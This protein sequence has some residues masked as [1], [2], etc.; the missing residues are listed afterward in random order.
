MNMQ[1]FVFGKGK[2]KGCSLIV[3][4]SC[5]F[6]FIITLFIKLVTNDVYH[7]HFLTSGN[8]VM[9]VKYSHFFFDSLRMLQSSL[10]MT[11]VFWF[12][13]FFLLYQNLGF[14]K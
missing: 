1:N 6:L 11:F 10:K 13:L 4:V 14:N 9:Q 7:I 2:G 12:C 5:F 8:I 3:N